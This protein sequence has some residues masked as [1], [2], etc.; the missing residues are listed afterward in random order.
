M[1]VLI[2]VPGFMDGD[3]DDK[4]TIGVLPNDMG[5]MVSVLVCMCVCVRIRVR[6]LWKRLSAHIISHTVVTTILFYHQSQ[7]RLERY[8]RLH[9]RNR[10]AKTAYDSRDSLFVFYLSYHIF[11]ASLYT[12]IDSR[13]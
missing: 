5:L 8:Y 9:D 1:S 13:R 4:R 3:E 2:M 6:Y 12:F 11:I 7:E 10:F